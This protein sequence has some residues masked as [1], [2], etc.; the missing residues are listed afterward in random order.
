[1]LADD[2]R[3]GGKVGVMPGREGLGHRQRSEC[4]P[5]VGGDHRDRESVLAEIGEGEQRF[6]GSDPA[7]G[8]DDP[9]RFDGRLLTRALGATCEGRHTHAGRELEPETA[10]LAED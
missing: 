1:V 7:S 8:D 2:A 3:Q 9:A 5:L 10:S 6:H 4:E